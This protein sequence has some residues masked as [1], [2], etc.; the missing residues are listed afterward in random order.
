MKVGD[1]VEA[2]TGHAGVI[3]DVEYMY[4]TVPHHSPLRSVEVLW[5]SEQP[6][7]SFNARINKNISSINIFAIKKVISHA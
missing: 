5:N 7:H 2:N 6:H 1:M 4:P 3:V